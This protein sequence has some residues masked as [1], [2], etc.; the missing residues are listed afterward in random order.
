MWTTLN[1]NPHEF[2]IHTNQT[3]QCSCQFPPFIDHEEPI[4]FRNL[5]FGVCS[6]MSGIITTNVLNLPGH[7]RLIVFLSKCNCYF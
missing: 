4:P 1:P 3:K 5:Q 6:F 7:V 2:P